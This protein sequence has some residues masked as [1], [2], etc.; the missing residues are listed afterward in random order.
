ML[1]YLNSWFVAFN[2]VNLKLAVQV[3]KTH[4]QSIVTPPH[5]RNYVV[6]EKF[7]SLDVLF[8]ELS[9]RSQMCSKVAASAAIISASYGGLFTF[10]LPSFRGETI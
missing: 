5:E 10:L 9:S 8:S 3:N 4:L 6:A 2:L 1:H 7:E